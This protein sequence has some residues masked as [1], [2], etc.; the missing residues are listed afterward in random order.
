MKRY[1]QPAEQRVIARNH[2]EHVRLKGAAYLPAGHFRKR[3]AHD[4][5]R[6]LCR[7][8]HYAKWQRNGG[9]ELTRQEERADIATREQLQEAGRDL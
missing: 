1:H 3:D 2:R 5:G 9:H 6:T 8:C 4:C 7:I